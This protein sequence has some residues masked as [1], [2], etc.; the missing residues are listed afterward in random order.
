MRAFGV[1]SFG[2]APAVHDLPIP[3]AD[4]TL[5]I[6]VKY[7]GVNPIDYKL[8]E[9]LTLTSKYPFVTGGNFYALDSATGQRLWSTTLGGGAIGGGVIT[10]SVGGAQKVAVAV[11]LTNILWPTKVVTGKI[12]IF[13]LPGS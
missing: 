4:N 8:R 3:A 2:K 1:Q 11:G 9:Q 12:V 10:Y 7:A 6:P 13:G 5:L